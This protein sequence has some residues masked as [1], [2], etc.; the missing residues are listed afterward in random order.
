MIHHKIE[1]E[2]FYHKNNTFLREV[3]RNTM[4]KNLNKKFHLSNK[5][6]FQKKK[7]KFGYFFFYENETISQD[8][9][10]GTLYQF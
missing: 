2:K 4:E 8:C 9:I 7:N 10:Y 6:K 3:I 1:I 5:F